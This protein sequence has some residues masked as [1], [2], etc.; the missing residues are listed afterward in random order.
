MQRPRAAAEIDLGDEARFWPCEEALTR[1]R[2]LAHGG[3]AEVVYE[4]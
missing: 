2:E 4:M 1:W 3:Q